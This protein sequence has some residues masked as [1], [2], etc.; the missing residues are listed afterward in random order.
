MY[1]IINQGSCGKTRKLLQLAS[2]NN[3]IV[4]CNNPL[5]MEVKARSYGIINIDIISYYDFIHD[6]YSYGKPIFIDEM[7]TF[8]N[9]IANK[10]LLGYTINNE[11]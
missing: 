4:V 11:E 10:K 3:G 9:T 6:E 8:V 1:K 5:A 7:D 2:E